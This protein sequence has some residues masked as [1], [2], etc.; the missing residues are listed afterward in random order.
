MAKKVTRRKFLRSVG[1]TAGAIGLNGLTLAGISSSSAQELIQAQHLSYLPLVMKEDEMARLI[2]DAVSEDSIAAP[3]NRQ[4]NYIIVSVTDVNGVPV[5]GLN[6]SNFQV[7]ALIVG[8][9]GALVNVTSVINAALPGFYLVNV[10]PINIETWKS[11]V[12]IFGVA[13]ERTGDQGQ[14]LAAVLMD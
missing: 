9:G 7:Q 1:I 10:V 5:T 11:G 4:P 2:V 3:G 13:V 12:Y 14:T 6:S 8:A